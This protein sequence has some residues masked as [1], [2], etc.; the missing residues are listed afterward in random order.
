MEAAIDEK[1]TV[2]ILI[3]PI[4]AEGGVIVPHE[5]YMLGLREICDQRGFS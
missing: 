2:A 1:K 3:E 4:Q 5:I